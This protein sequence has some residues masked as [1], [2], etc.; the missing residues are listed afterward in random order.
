M[1][2]NI[3]DTMNKFNKF[4]KSRNKFSL[5]LSLIMMIIYY[6]FVFCVGMFPDV[7][8]YK[9]GP[10]SVTLGIISGL[11]IIIKHSNHWN[12]HLCRK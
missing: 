12:L 5:T 8:G 11:A 4:N 10:S 1:Q 3:K 7:L 2:N 6:I 9:I